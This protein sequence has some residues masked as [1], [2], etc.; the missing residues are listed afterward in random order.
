MLNK[1][2]TIVD[3]ETTGMNGWFDRIIEIGMIRVENNKVVDEFK[4]LV[5]PETYVSPFI[6]SFT[7]INS[8]DLQDAPVFSAIKDKVYGL[9]SDAVFVA[10]NARFD[11]S[12]L[13]YEFK[14]TGISYNS[15]TLCTVKL[16][17]NLFPQ[18]RT[19]SLSAIIERYNFDCKNRHR[20]YDDAFV[21]WQFIQNLSKKLPATK[22]QEVIKKLLKST[23]SSNSKVAKQIENLPESPGVYIFYDKKN[24]PLYVGKSKNIK[25]RVIAHFSTDY[26]STRRLLMIKSIARIEYIRT[27]GELGA[28]IQ[29]S[30]LIKTLLPY[31]NR[32]LRVKKQLVTLSKDKSADGFLSLELEVINQIDNANFEK[33]LGVFK[34]K[35]SAKEVISHIAKKYSLCNKLLGVEK[36]KSSCFE[37]KLGRCKGAC[38][39]KEKKEKYNARFLIAFVENKQ[40]RPWPFKGPIEIVEKNEE[41]EL[42]ESFLVNNWCL[43]DNVQKGYE[44]SR[45]NSQPD[46]DIDTYKIISGF[47]KNRNPNY[48]VVKNTDFNSHISSYTNE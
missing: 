15:K 19:H 26:E 39:G 41:E 22:I 48:K 43:L 33:L 11:Y 12:F 27:A 30:H 32:T 37:Y 28:L 10:H 25:D 14:R 23:Y 31:F 1:P 17:R 4:S 34:N 36:T 35:R 5:N 46:F 24:L 18:F 13:K 38:I 40:F 42:Y 20:A 16:S 6:E 3:V 44:N 2:Y 45:I 21:L 8:N 7:G 9:L 29:E 47:I